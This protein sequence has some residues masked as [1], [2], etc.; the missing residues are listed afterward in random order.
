MGNVIPCQER[1]AMQGFKSSVERLVRLFK[2]SRDNW[3]A[4]A[5]ERQRRIRALEVTVRDLKQS[6]DDWRA[7]AL[8]QRDKPAAGKPPAEKSEP[9]EHKP[10]VER[11]DSAAQHQYPVPTIQ[12]SLRLVVEAYTSLRGTCKVLELLA[13][14]APSFVSV[15]VWLYRCGLYLLS[16]PL[17]RREDWILIVDHTL[18]LGVQKCLVILGIPEAELTRNGYSPTHRAL[19]L[20]ALEVSAT[21]SG[22]QVAEQLE[23]VHRQVG[24]VVQVIADHGA[25]L[26]KGIERFQHRHPE[27]ID[28]YD[29]S[30]RMATLLKQALGEEARWSAFLSECGRCRV[31]LQQTELAFLRPPRQRRTARFM[32]LETHLGWAER[33]LAY[34]ERGDFSAIAARHS[35]NWSRWEQLVGHVGPERA[36]P[37]RALIGIPYPDPAA[38]RQALAVHLGEQVETLDASFWHQADAG[39]RRFL[40]SFGWLLDYR[41]ELATY[42]ELLARAQLTQTHLKHHGLSRDSGAQ[43]AALLEQRP[44]QE[45]RVQHFT[46][47]ILEYLDAEGAKI[48]AKRTLLASSDA[49]ES[50]F[51]KYKA[52]T[53]RSPLREIGQR[54]LMIPLFLTELTHDLVRQ[55]LETVRTTDV[56]RWVQEHIGPS[57][58]AKRTQALRPAGEDTKTV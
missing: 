2:K 20:M 50:V 58:L 47:R 32:H 8:G 18:E 29:V 7:R 44:T 1:W 56:R 46:A 15:Q 21:S 36:A 54:V 3:K 6:R 52:F 26:R 55:A 33:L 39:R 40:D 19:Q 11:Q 10:P 48:P 38:F 17:E 57:M 51:G 27:V 16:R 53:E 42:S 41:H 30:H 28:T 22:E 12:L 4:K 45:P 9:E 14:A 37:L 13:A 23:R 5:L 24:G 35:L 34:H 43:V 31:A 49:I 25:D